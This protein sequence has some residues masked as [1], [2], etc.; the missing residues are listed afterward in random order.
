[1]ADGSAPLLAA[2]RFALFA[3]LALVGPGVA[4]QRLL[5]RRWDPALVLPLGLLFGAFTY[6][7]SL[8]VGAPW[9]FPV[10]VLAANLPLLLPGPGGKGPRGL[11]SEVRFR[12]CSFL[13]RCSPSPSTP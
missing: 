5:L 7:L 13:S 6:W 11:R 4:L 8:V 1:L 12:R 3:G 9:V 2:L 10:L